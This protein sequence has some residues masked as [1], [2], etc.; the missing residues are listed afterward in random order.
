MKLTF[1][2]DGDQ[3]WCGCEGRESLI[4]EAS[5]LFMEFHSDSSGNV[6]PIFGH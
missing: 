2:Q 1:E 4:V 6:R 3:N 5:T